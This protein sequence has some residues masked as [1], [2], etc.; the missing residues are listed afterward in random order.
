M[1]RSYSQSPDLWHVIE[2][3][4]RNAGDVVVVEGTV[5]REKREHI[6]QVFPFLHQHTI[7]RNNQL[8][9]L[10]RSKTRSPIAVTICDIHER[11]CS[12]KATN[13]S[14][15]M[16]G[17]HCLPVWVMRAGEDEFLSTTGT[18][19][20]LSVQLPL[21][22]K[23]QC[24]LS[25]GQQTWAQHLKAVWRTWRCWD[26]KRAAGSPRLVSTGCW[27]GQTAPTAPWKHSDGW[28]SSTPSPQEKYMGSGAA[29]NK[30]CP[31][32][33]T[34]GLLLLCQSTAWRDNLGCWRDPLGASQEEWTEITISWVCCSHLWSS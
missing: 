23:T 4:D 5:R 19:P 28:A 12:G 18:D 20:D 16:A 22:L 24:S 32:P 25:G 27:H 3:G 34:E 2:A 26:Q 21:C 14:T 9:F 29:W 11:H 7:Y 6:D 33:G 31:E 10:A 30:A 1:R 15:R 8:K 17:S 13:S